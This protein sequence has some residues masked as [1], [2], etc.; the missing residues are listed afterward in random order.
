M[1]KNGFVVSSECLSKH[2]I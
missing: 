1:T 2:V